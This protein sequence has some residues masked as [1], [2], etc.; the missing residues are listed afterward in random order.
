MTMKEQMKQV[1]VYSADGEP[2]MN[3]FTGLHQHIAIP[4]QD[5][6]DRVVVNNPVF[7][8]WKGFTYQK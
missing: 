1:P 7:T 8:E 2:L 6:R 3:P 4:K 5:K